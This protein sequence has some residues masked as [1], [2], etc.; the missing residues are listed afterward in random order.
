MPNWPS[1]SFITDKNITYSYN[2]NHTTAYQNHIIVF[3]FLH[4]M[5]EAAASPESWYV[6]TRL[7]GVKSQNT[8][9]F[10]LLV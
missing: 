1:Q 8:T 10:I 5:L 6:S 7:D 9:V 4:R 2:A 3:A